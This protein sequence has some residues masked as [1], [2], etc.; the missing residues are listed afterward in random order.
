MTISGKKPVTVAE[1]Q[2]KHREPSKADEQELRNENLRLRRQNERLTSKSSLET[3]E[4][5]HVL[6]NTVRRVRPSVSP[7]FAAAARLPWS[8]APCSPRRATNSHILTTSTYRSFRTTS[9]SSVRRG[10]PRRRPTEQSSAASRRH[11]DDCRQ[12]SCRAGGGAV[13]RLHRPGR[14]GERLIGNVSRTFWP[15]GL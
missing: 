13:D 1:R 10:S 11:R 8:R 6:I 4:R 5:R 7:E 2:T 12:V 14:G 3:E 15:N 9:R